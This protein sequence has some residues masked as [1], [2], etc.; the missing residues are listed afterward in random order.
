MNTLR[1]CINGVTSLAHKKIKNAVM[2]SKA[3]LYTDLC[4][5]QT[6]VQLTACKQIQINSNPSILQYSTSDYDDDQV[7]GFY[8]ML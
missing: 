6:D 5:E 4:I 2:G 3:F 1:L 8:G 7:D